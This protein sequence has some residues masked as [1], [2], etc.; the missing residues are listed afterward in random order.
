MKSI[1]QDIIQGFIVTV[2]LLSQN[3]LTA[4]TTEDARSEGAAR[5]PQVVGVLLCVQLVHVQVPQTQIS[6]GGA[7][8]EHLTTWAEGAGY[9]CRVIHCSGPSQTQPTAAAS[10]DVCVFNIITIVQEP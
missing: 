1:D 3:T 2:S 4:L 6:I 8:H 10:T 5:D 9:H 7:S